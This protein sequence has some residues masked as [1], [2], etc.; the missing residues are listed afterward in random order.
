MEWQDRTSYVKKIALYG[1]CIALA[2]VIGYLE[3]LIPIPFYLPGMKLGLSNIVIL[4]VMYTINLKSGLVVNLLRITLLSFLFG[5]MFGMAYSFAGAIVS[6]MGMALAIRSGYFSK[7]GV[8]ILGGILHN[9]G[10]LA[11]AIY[12][13]HNL[14]L[15]YY[16]PILLISGL[17]TGALNG[18]CLVAVSKR[19]SLS[20]LS[21]KRDG[22]GR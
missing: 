10:Q 7:I 6:F 15:Y 4:L 17:V 9:V 20:S 21:P 13:V 3:M 8:S 1:M 5:N 19:L 16:L 22:S 11:V 14:N 2:A 18:S 12:L